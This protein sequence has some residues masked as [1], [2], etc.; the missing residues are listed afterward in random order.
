MKETDS[1]KTFERTGAIKDYL[2]YKSSTSTTASVRVQ[3]K[4]DPGAI[5][6]VRGQEKN[7]VREMADLKNKEP[8]REGTI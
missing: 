8:E 3:E 7:S 5:A 2:Q 4:N 1:W 6:C